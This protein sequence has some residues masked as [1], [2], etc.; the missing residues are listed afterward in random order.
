MF[1][2]FTVYQCVNVFKYLSMPTFML[3]FQ[4][5]YGR[6]P[7]KVKFELFLCLLYD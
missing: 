5:A 6:K 7:Q 3:A 2:L 1:H 4:M